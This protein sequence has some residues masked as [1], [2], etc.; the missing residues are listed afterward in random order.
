MKV[1]IKSAKV[2]EPSSTFHNK[3]VDVLIS[4]GKIIEISDAI[5]AK[6]DV[7]IVEKDNLHISA[8]WFDPTVSFG[9]PGF[10]EN[11]TLE[12]GMAAAAAGGFTAVGMLPN[13]NPSIDKKSD[14]EFLIKRS[15]FNAVSIYPIGALSKKC[16]GKEI[17]ESFDMSNSGAIAFGDD[18]SIENEKLMEVSLLYNK[19]IGKPILSFPKT[20]SISHGGQ[21]NEGV[22]STNLGLKGIPNL[23]EELRVSR[24]LF[25]TEYTE[26]KIHFQN[27]S[28]DKSVELIK[29]AKKKGLDV[30]AQVAV[31]SVFM[32]DSELE[33]FDTRFKLNPPLRTQVEIKALI[34]GLKDGTIDFVSSDHRPKD[35]ERKFKEFDHASFGSV[36]LESAFGALNKVLS[37]VMDLED[38]IALISSKPRKRFGLS[39]PKL[40]VGVSAELTLF[41]PE[42]SLM[43][44]ESQIK[45]L[46]KNSAFVGKGLKGKVYGVVSKGEM[47]MN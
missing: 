2:I 12:S 27:I 34:K 29:E 24:D 28:T 47:V 9:E 17:S 5:E 38:I 10:E 41:N 19:T 36:G 35:I 4:N 39:Q 13:T 16:E 23:S 33:E 14:V 37:S 8:G 30:S 20:E 7:I 32:D 31:Y 15:S 45:S 40:E 44:E 42:E 18:K 11:E 26:G 46:S 25:L 22:N 3:T 6:D 43:F 21:M 1:L